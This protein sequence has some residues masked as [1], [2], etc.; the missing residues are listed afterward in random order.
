MN[1]ERLLQT[2][3]EL[4]EY[5]N[6]PV[7]D[8]GFNMERYLDT[9]NPCIVDYG[10]NHCGTTA[11]IAGHVFVHAIHKT[12]HLACI[13]PAKVSIPDRAA[14]YLQLTFRQS[15]ELFLVSNYEGAVALDD[16]TPEQAAQACENTAE[17]GDPKWRTII[18]KEQIT[19]FL[20]ERYV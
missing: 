20:Q 15:E 11:C 4:R 6:G 7:D 17:Y 3:K 19:P 5:S 13:D 9:D 8:F 10:H 1:K 2:A 16:I 12:K 18:P 14:E